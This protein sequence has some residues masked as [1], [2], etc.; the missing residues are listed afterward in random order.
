MGKA[1]NGP[2]GPAPPVPRRGH[3]EGAHAIEVDLLPQ[4]GVREVVLGKR[5]ELGPAAAG[6]LARR[7]PAPLTSALRR[8]RCRSTNLAGLAASV[9]LPDWY[10][11]MGLFDVIQQHHVGPAVLCT[12]TVSSTLAESHKSAESL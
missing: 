6:L 10:P 3:T 7:P 9:L 4:L 1:D 12:R 2:S 8:S 5:L 11:P